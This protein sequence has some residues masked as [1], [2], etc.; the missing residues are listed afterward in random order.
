L[1]AGTDVILGGQ[2]TTRS[3]GA[4]ISVSES[5]NISIGGSL[6]T[7][8]DVIADAANGGNITF[9]TGGSFSASDVVVE[10]S[11]EP[12]VTLT[13]GANISFDI[14]TSLIFNGGSFSLTIN[15]GNG[16]TIGTGGD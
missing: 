2:F 8:S 13:D 4:N 5:G 1:N 16:C 10:T 6:A 3:A 14:G 7:M 11:V 15:D 12:G 9:A